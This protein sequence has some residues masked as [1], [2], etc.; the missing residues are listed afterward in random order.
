MGLSGWYSCH[1]AKH[2]IDTWNKCESSVPCLV[3]VTRRNRGREWW[4]MQGKGWLTL[5]NAGKFLHPGPHCTP[6]ETNSCLLR[7]QRWTPLGNS[8]WWSIYI[9]ISSLPKWTYLS[10]NECISLKWTYLSRSEWLFHEWTYLSQSECISPTVNVS[11]SKWMHL[12]QSKRISHK[13]THFSQ[14]EYISLKTNTFLSKWT[15]LS[16]ITISLSKLM[17]LSQSYSLPEGSV[18]LTLHISQS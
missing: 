14:S 16:Q 1:S 5:P 7:V 2:I 9:Y 6:T 17:C 8:S 13:W 3:A 15:N 10:Q 11:L 4:K 18:I 12:S